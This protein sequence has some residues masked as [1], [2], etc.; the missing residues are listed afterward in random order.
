MTDRQQQILETI[1]REYVKTAEPVS[2]GWLAEKCGFD[3]S[4]ATL[5]AEMNVLEAE[6]Y[7]QQPHTSAGRIPTDKA[8]RV[9]VSQLLGEKKDVLPEKDKRVIDKSIDYS[10]NSYQLSRN[11]SRV[12]AE[13]THEFAVSGIVDTE[14][15][16]K[17]GLGNMFDLPEARDVEWTFHLGSIF[18]QFED[19]FSDWLIDLDDSRPVVRIGQGA[20]LKNESVIITKYPLPGG[21][22][23]VSAVIGPMRMRYGRNFA[24]LEYISQKLN[25]WFNFCNF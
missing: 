22:E 14:E 19:L 16:F 11:L 25:R 9:F 8:Y 23:G 10:D 6:G 17:A 18:D 24:I 5:R 15:F 4:P 2:S 21:Q 12:I 3:C 1:I 13:L 20:P 7:L